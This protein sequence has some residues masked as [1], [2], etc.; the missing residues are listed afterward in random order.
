MVRFAKPTYSRCLRSQPLAQV[1]RGIPLDGQTA[2]MLRV[3]PRLRRLDEVRS[4]LDA[5][6]VCSGGFVHRLCLPQ[7]HGSAQGDG[8][9]ASVLGRLAREFPLSNCPH[10]PSLEH[11]LGQRRSRCVRKIGD[12]GRDDRS[13]S[14]VRG[15]LRATGRHPDRLNIA[16][17]GIQQ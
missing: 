6:D 8:R 15:V 1:R 16:Q 14:T 5:A 10:L 11:A 17:A 2:Q 4:S 13:L 3:V 12:E 7:W 9:V